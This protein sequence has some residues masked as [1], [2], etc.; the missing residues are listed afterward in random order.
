MK[1]EINYGEQVTWGE[2]LRFTGFV[3]S[4]D[5]HVI[6]MHVEKFPRSPHGNQPHMDITVIYYKEIRHEDSQG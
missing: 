3:F 2:A 4:D 6:S 1:N 5:A